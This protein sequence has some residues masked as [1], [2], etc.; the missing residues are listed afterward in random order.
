MEGTL[1]VQPLLALIAIL[2]AEGVDPD[3]LIREA[4]CE[5]ALFA[6]S[7]NTI[8]FSVVGRLLDRVATVTSLRYPGLEFGRRSGLEVLGM[9]GRAIQVAPDLGT[10]LRSL[11]LYF[12]LH[13]RGAIPSLWQSGDRVMFGYT[14][15]CPDLTG[16]D[17]IYDAALAISHNVFSGLVG[18]EWVSTEVHMFRAPPED[19]E[20]FRQHFRARLRFGTE[21]AA[22]VFPADYLERPLPGAD[23]VAYAEAL[24]DLEAIDGA[25]EPGLFENKVRRVLHRKLVG[26][27]GPFGIDL[28]EIAQL[29]ELHPRTLNR[30][31]RTEGTSFN[32]LLSEAR[33]RIAQQL[34]RD[35]HLQVGEIAFLL[36]YAESASFN[37]AF[38]RWTGTTATAWRSSRR[39]NPK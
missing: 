32:A 6:D 19:V 10:A 31:L 30:R 4:G 1:R 36:G 13:D 25:S 12:H 22:I 24:R 5:P 18:R 7:E 20:P 28:H 38:R 39:P 23:P 17:H 26:G 35:T 33:C 11:I 21:H 3:A 14:L 9:L 27:E 34:L 2:E 15:Y 16:V 8:E 29:F 37:H